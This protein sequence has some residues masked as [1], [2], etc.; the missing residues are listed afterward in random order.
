M[1]TTGAARRRLPV[2]PWNVAIT[3]AEDP[4]VGRNH[5]VTAT[6]ES[7]CHAHN[8]TVEPD[9]PVDPWNGASPKLKIPPSEATSQ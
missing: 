3:E 9:S 8:R 1:P 6:V 2:D 7:R 4:A 5:P